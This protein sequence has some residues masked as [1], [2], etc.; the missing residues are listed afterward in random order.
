MVGQTQ[1][2]MHRY[3]FGCKGI[4]AFDTDILLQYEGNRPRYVIFV[5]QSIL[6]PRLPTILKGFF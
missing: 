4:D 3:Y 2:N 1:R 6:I 5:L